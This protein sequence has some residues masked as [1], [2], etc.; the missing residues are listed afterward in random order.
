[1]VL[2]D[3]SQHAVT[4]IEEACAITAALA[5]LHDQGLSGVALETVAVGRG[6]QGPVLASLSHLA[7]PADAALDVAR[8]ARRVARLLPQHRALAEDPYLD[9]AALWRKV[10]LPSSQ[11]LSPIPPSVGMDEVIEH[12]TEVLVPGRSTRLQLVSIVACPGH[13]GPRVLAELSRSLRHLQGPIVVFER[14]DG[15]RRPLVAR[16]LDA[17]AR[18]VAAFAPDTLHGVARAIRAIAEPWAGELVALAPQLAQFKL[19]KD[20]TLPEQPAP[21]AAIAQLLRVM[22]TAR[23]PLVL[24][25][26]RRSPLDR[27]TLAVLEHLETHPTAGYLS[28][29]VL[30]PS[31]H[32]RGLTDL[33]TTEV[34]IDPLDLYACEELAQAAL[35]GEIVDLDIIASSLLTASG[36]AVDRAWALLRGW[37]TSGVVQQIHGAWRCRALPLPSTLSESMS[38]PAQ[39]LLQLLRLLQAP[40]RC[41]SLP[42]TDALRELLNSGHVEATPSGTLRVTERGNSPEVPSPASPKALQDLHRQ[43]I[44]LF[45]LPTSEHELARLKHEELAT[46]PCAADQLAQRHLAAARM[47][48]VTGA[49][50]QALW[51]LECALERSPIHGFGTQV[52]H[53]IGLAY[54]DLGRWEEAG[55][56]WSRAAQGS[57]DLLN[58]L[59]HITAGVL[60]LNISAAWGPAEALAK[61]GLALAG[62]PVPTTVPSTLAAISSS[63]LVPNFWRREAPPELRDALCGLYIPLASSSLTSNPKLAL[64]AVVQAWQHSRGLLGPNAALVKA[65]AAAVLDVLDPVGFSGWSSQGLLDEALAMGEAVGNHHTRANTHHCAA[66]VAF[67]RG[68]LEQGLQHTDLSVQQALDG[69]RPQLAALFRLTGLGHA[70]HHARLPTLNRWLDQ[71]DR[72]S[73]A[74]AASTTS[75]RLLLRARLADPTVSTAITVHAAHLSSPA[76]NLTVA[77]TAHAW[78]AEAAAVNQQ[79]DIAAEQIKHATTQ[80]GRMPQRT[81]PRRELM[82]AQL[83]L[84]TGKGLGASQREVERIGHGLSTWPD[85]DDHL[86]AHRMCQQVAEGSATA[87]DVQECINHLSLAL[88]WRAVE[89]SSACP[90]EFA[91]AHRVGAMLR[92]NLALPRPSSH[93][94]RDDRQMLRKLVQSL[95]RGLG[96]HTTL[97]VELPWP[98]TSRVPRDH[99]RQ[100]LLEQLLVATHGYRTDEPLGVRVQITPES[101]AAHM[102]GR[103]AGSSGDTVHRCLMSV[104]G[105]R[106][107]PTDTAAD[108]SALRELVDGLGGRLL[109]LSESDDGVE[110]WLPE[111]PPPQQ[112]RKVVFVVHPDRR[113]REALRATLTG[114]GHRVEAAAMPEGLTTPEAAWAFVAPELQELVPCPRVVP[115]L[116]RNEDPPM[117]GPCLRW[118][119][120]VD[121]VARQFDR[122]N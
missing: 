20:L 53:L 72:I 101:L 8:V 92:K 70:R 107:T 37:H 118:P 33:I 100:V 75:L 14:E 83:A 48:L 10:Q 69:Q 113:I 57:P 55:G 85:A 56:A 11:G 64:Y 87:D 31:E 71:V 16:W 6:E 119:C 98:L 18:E 35:P 80:V 62:F 105:V 27:L 103:I 43:A 94:P 93:T 1:M 88:P 59:R 13:G 91:S 115:V 111:N 2:P 29:G 99:L 52:H 3:V 38:E 34:V 78:L 25:A 41:A 76:E 114:L 84:E 5:H 61:M 51:H 32:R 44:A 104:Q 65:S 4:A 112:S 15:T 90:S 96:A 40:A 109:Q 19:S 58:S 7:T 42:H 82:L 73:P 121:Q 28:V 86:L 46:P 21:A 9:A 95:G 79:L 81:L 117:S 17:A 66:L 110:V 120:T 68:D 24:L 74:F 108:G 12:L 49:P 67:A 60:R 22:G 30:L 122:S 102:T 45:P 50:D 97:K 77:W 36:G 116:R 89:L 26:H 23:H 106:A 39:A 63:V 47:M 54:A